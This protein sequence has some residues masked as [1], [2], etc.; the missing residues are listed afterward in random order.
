MELVCER[1][2]QLMQLEGILHPIMHPSLH[3]LVPMRGAAV[4]TLGG[5]AVRKFFPW[6]LQCRCTKK[7]P[8][9]R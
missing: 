6:A 3:L 9:A 8:A 5:G 4:V 2:V 7:R 1:L